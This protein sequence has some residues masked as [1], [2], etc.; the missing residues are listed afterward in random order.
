MTEEQ[1]WQIWMWAT[2]LSPENFVAKIR[3]TYY[4]DI[5]NK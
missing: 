4:W 5:S 1:A 2:S 3:Q